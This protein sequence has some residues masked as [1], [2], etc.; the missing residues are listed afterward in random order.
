M[1]E[2]Y[3]R[4]GAGIKHDETKPPL[5]YNPPEIQRGMARAFGHGAK[6]Y[7]RWNWM[8]GLAVSRLL[9]ACLRHLL[10]W[11]WEE[12]LD[13]QSGLSHLDH[14]AAN[15]AMLMETVKRSPNLDDRPPHQ[16]DGLGVAGVDCLDG[17]REPES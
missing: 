6:K 12:T 8:G 13:P 9:A 11:F 5:F 1:A 4:Q 7:D 15:L 17:A 16:S 3:L 2:E 14:A 10:S